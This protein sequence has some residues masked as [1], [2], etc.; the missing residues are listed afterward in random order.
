MLTE[1]VCRWLEVG[2]EV[3]EAARAGLPGLR[4][5]EVQAQLCF[6]LLCSARFNLAKTYLTGAPCEFLP[7]R[8]RDSRG[9]SLDNY[10]AELFSSM[11]RAPIVGKKGR[12][13]GG[14]GGGEGGWDAAAEL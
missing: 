2:E 10:I 12:G 14:G 1:G 3:L 9:A 8:D 7:G 11:C 13:G 4:E 5:Q 6:A